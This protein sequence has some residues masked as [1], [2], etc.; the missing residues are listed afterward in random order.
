M[1]DR[2]DDAETDLRVGRLRQEVAACRICAAFLPLGPRPIVQ[3][4]RTSRILIIGQAPGAKVHQS[5][6]PWADDSGDR[7]R[8]WMAVDKSTFYDPAMV[9][10]MPMGFC[11]P[12]KGKSGDLP[13][14]PECLP[15]WHATILSEMPSVALTLIVGM[16]AQV[17]YLP[18]LGRT[19]TER[20]RNYA[21]AEGH[22]IPLPHPAWR[23]VIWQ[24]R[25]PW[26]E[27]ELLPVLRERV[28]R[29][30]A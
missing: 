1:V 22:K 25:N 12:G 8:E 2:S 27:A 20:V 14:R 13:P 15:K 9:A 30:L 24:R 6:I 19:L 5:G 7:L 16:Y 21:V 3:F 4:G 17:H 23:S 18:T 26:F 29:A 11:Y 28:S 10:L